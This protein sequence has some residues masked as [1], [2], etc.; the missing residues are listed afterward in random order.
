[1]MSRA[2][3]SVLKLREFASAGSQK[4]LLP[5]GVAWERVFVEGIPCE[6]IIPAM[7]NEAVILHLHGGGWVLG[8]YNNHRWKA[9]HISLAAGCRALAV[10]YRTAPEHPFPAALDDCVT[11]YRWLVNNGVPP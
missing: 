9:A 5:K 4:P 11:A 7:K 8:L 2:G 6:W 1:M 10:D 3:T